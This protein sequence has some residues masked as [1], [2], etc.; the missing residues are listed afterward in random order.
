MS[1]DDAVPSKRGPGGTG[2][3]SLGL[4]PAETIAALV[5]SIDLAEDG[6][7]LFTKG[8]RGAGFAS[9]DLIQVDIDIALALSIDLAEKF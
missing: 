4:I 5:F 8:A 1:S 9:L 3:A 7:V 2:F 6:A